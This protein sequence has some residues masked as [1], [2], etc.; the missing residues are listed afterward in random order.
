MR[1]LIQ[2]QPQ[3]LARFCACVHHH[4]ITQ[5]SCDDVRF[6]IF[7]HSFILQVAVAAFGHGAIVHPLS[8]NAI[9]R[10]PAGPDRCACS[11]F[12]GNC[13]NGQCVFR[14]HAQMPTGTLRHP[15]LIHLIVLQCTS[16][17]VHFTR[18]CSLSAHQ[19]PLLPPRRTV[20]HQIVLLVQPRL[21]YRL[22]EV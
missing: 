3:T 15:L 13:S 18:A 1:P 4:Q 2:P 17:I 11:N 16:N 12:T 9:D 7:N 10:A 22:P 19:L 20:S 8:R 6:C 21:L 14:R 5:R